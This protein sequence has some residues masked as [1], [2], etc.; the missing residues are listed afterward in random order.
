MS[1]HTILGSGGVI[2]HEL[3]KNLKSYTGTD[4]R[5]VSRNPKKV[6]PTD[7]IVSANLIN[8]QETM[9]A[10]KGSQVAYLIVGLQYKT[11]IWQKSWPVIMSNVVNSC[12]EHST[13][14]VFFDN[15]YSYGKVD[16]W[17]TEETP[18][19]P[20]SKKGEVRAKIAEQLMNEV[21]KGNIE[22]M[23]TRSADFYGPN[24]INTMVLPMVFEKLKNGKKA[25]W[26]LNEKVRHSMT[27]T[28]DA[29][30]ATALLGN[31]NEAYNQVW[32][33]PTDKNALTG[34]EFIKL[35]AKKFGVEPKYSVLNKFMINM[36]GLFN[37]IAKESLEMLYQLEY[38]YLFDSSKF[39]K[40]FSPATTYEK[41][42]EEIVKME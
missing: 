21:K 38:E 30:R 39:E 5:L 32:H 28:P 11:K 42:I 34:E 18:A 19:N 27:F 40:Q 10:L 41:G 14:L 35:V 8:K 26:V 2:G 16:G 37:S 9:N 22:A 29:G 24:A 13:K 17:M 23:I 7:E 12:K 15:V 1:R 31:T 20:C 3:A 4:I 36:A 6:N 25:N 33:L